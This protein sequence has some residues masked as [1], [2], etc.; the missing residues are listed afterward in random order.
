MRE[1]QRRIN[2]YTKALPRM[3]EKV[4]ACLILLCM[5]AV[6]F[7]TVSF[8]WLIRSVNPEVAGITTN[9]AAN[10]NLEI[11]LA[12]GSL[13]DPYF[14]AP[15]ES[16]IGDGLL[17]ITERNKTW[18]NLINLSD[19][20][21]GLDELVLRPAMLNDASLLDSPLYSAIYGVGGRYESFESEFKYATW[22]PSNE[23]ILG[24]FEVSDE[25]GVRA[26]ASTTVSGEGAQIV[27]RAERGTAKG[28]ND[29]VAQKYSEMMSADGG[30]LVDS[31]ASVMGTFMTAKLNESDPEIDKADLGNISKLIDIFE[32]QV[33][34][35]EKNSYAALA[36]F[37]VVA[38]T[39]SKDG[40]T[41]YTGESIMTFVKST[42]AETKTALKNAGLQISG[43][44]QFSKDYATIK[45]Q[46]IAL[47][48]LA[49][50]GSCKWSALEPIMDKL[51]VVSQCT[52]SGTQVGSL[53]VSAALKILGQSG[54][55]EAKINNGVLLNFEQR[56]GARMDI[57]TKVSA[58]YITTVSIDAHVTT[59]ATVPSSFAKDLEYGDAVFESIP[60]SE[61]GSVLFMAD[62][63]YGLA[64]DFWVRTNISNSFL[65]LEG[66]VLSEYEDVPAV[67]KDTNGNDVDIYVITRK[68]TDD[69]GE[70]VYQSID[71]YKSGDKWYDAA[72]KGEIALQSGETPVRK[73][74]SV[75]NIY[76]YEGENRVWEGNEL[77]STDSSTQG[78]GSCYVYYA[79]TPEDQARSLE[80]LK[81]MN[82]VFIDQKGTKLA[83]AYMDTER[84]YASNGKVVVP[85]KLRA[86]A[87]IEIGED[88]FGNKKQAI[89]LLEKNVATLITA[90]VYLDGS[91]LSNENVLSAADI[92]GQ[93]NIQFGSSAEL[94]P[95]EDERLMGEIV[96]VE[97]SVSHTDFD[98]D[99]LPEGSDMTTR[100]TLDIEGSTPATVTAFFLRSINST[101]G[102][103]EDVMTFTRDANGDWVADYT[104]YAPGNYILKSVQIDGIDFSLTEQ[105]TVTING[106]A[107]KSINCAPESGTNSIFTTQNS[108]YADVSLEFSTTDVSRMPKEV[109][110]RF[111]DK[112]GNSVNVELRYNSNGRWTG[113]AI[114]LN[115]GEYTL[116]YL[117]LDGDYV[118]VPEALRSTLTINLGLKVAIYT[119]S[120]IE[121]LFK[122]DEMP[123]NQK[124]LHMQVKIFDNANNELQGLSDVSLY[125]SMV[126]SSLATYQMYDELEWNSTTSYYEGYFASKVGMYK[127]LRVEVGSNILT[128][129]MEAPSFTIVS[130]VPPT[131]SMGNSV[132]YQYKSTSETA[133]NPATLAV[134][135]N[136]A[137]ALPG[138][139]FVVSR[140]GV[141]QDTVLT[142]EDG[143]VYLDST[144]NWVVKLP[145]DLDGTQDGIW[146]I[147][148]IRIWGVYTS[149]GVAYT[150]ESPLIFNASTEGNKWKNVSTTVVSTVLT[151]LDSGGVTIDG[152]SGM[153]VDGVFLQT[154]TVNGFKLTVADKLGGAL[155]AEIS[156][157]KVKF[158][159]NNDSSANGGY[160]FSAVYDGF[161]IEFVKAFDASGN[162]DGKTFVQKDPIV[163]TYAGTYEFMAYNG[164][165]GTDNYNI[166]TAVTLA[167]D[168]TSYV[169]PI[170]SAGKHTITVKSTTPSVK[171]T[172]ISPTGTFDVDTNSNDAN[173]SHKTSTTAP[174]FNDSTATV[175]FK[176]SR[177]GEGSTCSPY[178]HKYTRPNVSITLSGI[179]YATKAELNFGEGARV[180][181]GSTQTSSYSW[182]ADG[183]CTRNI[184]YL[185]SE[186]S[187]TAAG[188]IRCTNLMLTDS[189]GVTYS[190][191]VSIT[192]NN[193]Y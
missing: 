186:T 40:F 34:E 87:S 90:V 102:T 174:T 145:V 169:I 16:K 81:T 122:G 47:K 18:G 139:Q 68:I 191:N 54:V 35:A 69:S 183:V 190:V 134:M 159:H 189:K 23:G 52:L 148:E 63:T 61:R 67:G 176:C 167:V 9:I 140:N 82:I 53:G 76:G 96:K 43:L 118:E 25:L 26:I 143:T 126:G 36:N 150:E 62:N 172:G 170:T 91:K 3:R 100:I 163:L 19:P 161:T 151:T 164:S 137:S 83:E 173:G 125:Y 55:K 107:V 15:G 32:T 24:H 74:V 156:T 1:T 188:T 92:Q 117:V 138:I 128:Q 41:P 155:K 89:T 113:R 50:G 95:V 86:D 71:I 144:G 101:Q 158:K 38:R 46:N 123:D 127:F 4:F 79:D 181:D 73:M 13:K 27:Y 28:S 154:H 59:T 166:D 2:E 135:L 88:D 141:R 131:F 116:R 97:A 175:Y 42:E 152:T 58:R 149:S 22:I 37:Q 78:S 85:M 193:P 179:G 185:A 105:P 72:S 112:R 153:T 45:E 29:V 114:F 49:A 129:A 184:G 115:S 57:T 103:R 10:G 80:L 120:P 109:Q 56:T 133:A 5:S 142:N 104:F 177:S 111:V 7:T 182:T 12:S 21:Y 84:Y 110:G 94:A 157:A 165:A 14:S 8:A 168:A 146:A 51:V 121:F 147:E 11:A 192:I 187:K 70:E 162:W 44:Y 64:V 160:T 99:T 93:L 17:S 20:S 66:N 106:F 180:Y 136:N 31:L 178:S 77:L 132:G 30:K 39:G 171:I 65:M 124:Q 130:P 60:E 33:L 6:M 48:N 119:K 108:T 75:E 98:F